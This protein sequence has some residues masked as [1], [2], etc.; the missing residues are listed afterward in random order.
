M[1]SLG[2]GIKDLINKTK[3]SV[4]RLLGELGMKKKKRLKA[5]YG[6]AEE[7]KFD[8]EYEEEIDELKDENN[9]LRNENNILSKEIKELKIM[10]GES[11]IDDIKSL[12]LNFKNAVITLY[13][14][15]E[16]RNKEIKKLNKENKE[17][18]REN[19]KLKEVIK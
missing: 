7:V 8:K 10:L 15:V 9:R 14:E 12:S 1:E 18:K 19:R 6:P 2:G 11:F 4:D 3:H 13:L 17:L 16:Y 5:K